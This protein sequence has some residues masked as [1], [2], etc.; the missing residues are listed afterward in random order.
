[1]SSRDGLHWHRWLEAFMRPGLQ[2][3]RRWQR[4]N[5]TTWGI[6]VTRS[7]VLGMPDELSLYS[8]EAYYSPDNRLRRYTLRTDGFV[9][10]HAPYSGGELVTRPL[11]FEGKNLVLNYSTSAAGSIRVEVTDGNGKPFQGFVLDDCLE[12]YGDEIEKVVEWESGSD[13]GRLAGQV[14]RLRFALKDVDLYSLRFR[15]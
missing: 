1:M 3:E 9:S 10:V 15:P 7:D 11:T 4:N 14:V 6:L 5:M 13:V 8:S 2:R 12:I